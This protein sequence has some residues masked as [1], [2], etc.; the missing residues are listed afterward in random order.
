[1]LNKLRR[2]SPRLILLAGAAFVTT[3]G[4]AFAT[5]PGST[6]VI[7]GCYEKRTGILRVIDTEAGKRCLA[8]ETAISWNQKGE[9]GEAGVAGAPGTQ[10]SQGPAGPQGADGL[11]GLR[12]EQGP[13]GDPGE[14]GAQGL[15]GQGVQGERGP[16]G[17]Q[18]EQGVQGIQGERGPQGPAGPAGTAQW[19]DGTGVVKT[20]AK[21]EIRDIGDPAHVAG[22]PAAALAV[23]GHVRALPVVGMWVTQSSTPGAGTGYVTW[24]SEKTRTDLDRTHLGWAA[25]SD[26]VE[27]RTSGYYLVSVDARV[28]GLPLECCVHARVEVVK[29]IPGLNGTE[30]D[31]PMC[32]ASELGRDHV[33]L[34]CTTMEFIQAGHAVRVFDPLDN[35]PSIGAPTTIKI[36]KLN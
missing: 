36:Y 32:G 5:I 3:A 22:P 2:R 28:S 11:Q 30:S 21:V 27:I 26:R 24:N 1:M 9:K 23:G 35:G 4:V 25:G 10:G 17:P 19:T 12:G 33:T 8:F 7:N 13:K 6:G 20:A 14:Q 18:G 16:Q 31:F 15:P 29:T 34:S